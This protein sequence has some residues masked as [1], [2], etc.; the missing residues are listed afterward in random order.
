[1]STTATSPAPVR[2]AS[3]DAFRGL[4]MLYMASE[5]WRLPNLARKFPDNPAWQFIAWHTSHVAWAGGSAWDLIQPAFMFM[6]GVALPFS[7]A[8]RRARG[9]NLKQLWRHALW[10]AVVLI[11]L[12]IFLRSTNRP[13]TYFTFEDVLTQIGLGYLF[14]FL[15]G[16]QRVRVQA[17]AAV[18][19]LVLYWGAFALY[20]APGPDFDFQRVGVPADWP[21]HQKGFAAH[22]DKNSNLA[23]AA[24]TWF[25]NLFPREKPFVFNAGGY[26]TLNFVPSLTT[27]IFGLLAGGLL[28]SA[29]SSRDKLQWL[30]GAGAAGIATGWLLGIAG[31]CPVVKRIWTPSWALVSG[32]W[33]CLVLAAF[34]WVID[35]RG[36]SRW[37]YGLRAVGMNSIAI[38][39]M[40]HLWDRFLAQAVKIHFGW[41]LLALVPE[42][43]LSFLPPFIA[44]SILWWICIW[45]DRRK[46]YIRI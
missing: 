43:A 2:L 40:A 42:P 26:Q 7:V 27:M 13:M 45:M 33:V 30:A 16:W 11:A 28:R 19:I 34:Y 35:V 3:L 15:L 18:L 8:N 10:R 20:P 38:Y 1:M 22:W 6:V 46:L 25:L 9:Q 41:N 17:A 37:S 44:W 5:I 4:T 29:K 23:A 36:I 12:G 31:L 32:G 21:H 14:L 24:D 39:C